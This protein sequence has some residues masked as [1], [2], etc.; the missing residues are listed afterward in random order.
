MTE[1][2][3]LEVGRLTVAPELDSDGDLSV[4]IENSEYWD[5][6]YLTNVQVIALRDH[7]DALLKDHEAQRGKKP[8]EEGYVLSMD[9][10]FEFERRWYARVKGNLS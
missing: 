3:A 5:T 8:G 7:L 1:R 2:K 9:E 4:E 10:R 6:T